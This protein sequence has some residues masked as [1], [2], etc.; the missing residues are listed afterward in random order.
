[1]TK[2]RPLHRSLDYRRVE[3]DK[4]NGR[5]DSLEVAFA[6]VWEDE[7]QARPGLNFGHGILQDLMFKRDC[8]PLPRT[9]CRMIIGQRDAAI[10]ATVVQWLGTNVGG[11]FLH[12][13]FQR[14]G[15]RLLG[16]SELAYERALEQREERLREREAKMRDLEVGWRDVIATVRKNGSAESEIDRLRAIEDAARAV[17]ERM[18]SSL[19]ALV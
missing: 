1:M 9:V 10:V 11:G 17:R 16:P 6:D 7:N 13:V 5:G 3:W 8:S 15:W 12:K 4:A 18:E 19:M 2:K 14:A